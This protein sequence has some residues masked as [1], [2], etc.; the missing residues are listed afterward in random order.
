MPAEHHLAI[1]L[2]IAGLRYPAVPHRRRQP[3]F[4]EA[5][6]EDKFSAQ[7]HYLIFSVERPNSTSKIVMIQKRTTTCVSFQPVCSK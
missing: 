3:R 1:A 5:E 7:F 6:H 4:A 2:A